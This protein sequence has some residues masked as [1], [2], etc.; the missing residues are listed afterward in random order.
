MA[1]AL[2][3]DR[4]GS[5]YEPRGISPKQINISDEKLLKMDI[6]P[7]CQT[8]FEGWFKSVNDH[9][10]GSGYECFHCGSH[11]VNWNADFD[12]SDMGYEGEGIVHTC[13]CADCGAEIEY[14][15]KIGEDD[16]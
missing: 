4:C 1:R 6:C 10:K 15:I 5:F 14:R 8:D 2:K 11:S 13:T 3:C 16:G 12:F 9:R 7:L